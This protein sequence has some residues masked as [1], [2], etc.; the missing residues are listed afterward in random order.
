MRG[1]ELALLGPLRLSGKLCFN[2]TRKKRRTWKVRP[3]RG[4]WNFFGGREEATDSISFSKQSG[5]HELELPSFLPL[6]VQDTFLADKELKC[7]YKASLDGFSAYKFHGCTDFKGPCVVLGLTRGGLR[8]GGFNPLGFRS[9]DDYYDTFKAFLFYC[10]Q[11][12]S[13][14][15]ILPKIGGSGAAIFDYARGGPQFGADGLLIGPPL[16]PVMG[17]LSGPDPNKGEGDLSQAKSRLGLSYACR[18]DGKDSIFGDDKKATVVEIEVFT[19]PAI[20]DMY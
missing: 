13:P 16:V 7:C 4:L 5:Y 15:V 9:T 10:P 6:L 2:T 17:G 20:R 12:D 8:F 19:C 1:A 14:P 18:P 3:V 11:G